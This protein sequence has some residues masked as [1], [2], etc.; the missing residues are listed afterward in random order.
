MARKIKPPRIRIPKKIKRGDI[1]TVKIQA[2]YPSIT[3]LGTIGD[4]DDFMRKEPARYL[5][6]M[7]VTYNGKEVRTFFMSSAVSENPRI[8]FPLKVN[9]PGTLKVVFTSNRD[10]TF[11]ASKKIEL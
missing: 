4:T 1:I 6:Q 9:E 5:N 2:K 11:E 8:E 10:E 7:I 3:G